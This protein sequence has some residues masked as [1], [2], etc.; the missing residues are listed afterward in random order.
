ILTGA[1]AGAIHRWDAVTGRPLTP[2]GAGD[3]V[4]DQ[5]LATPDGRH[6]VTR[7]QYGDAHLWDARTGAHLRQFPVSY[8]SSLALSPDGRHLVWA[9]ADEGVRFTVPGEP[10]AI[11]TGSRLRLYDLA[12]GRCVGRFG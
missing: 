3:S 6:V 1:V 2:Q 11:Y 9:E 7:G 8:H 12:A 4:V 10:N 5:I